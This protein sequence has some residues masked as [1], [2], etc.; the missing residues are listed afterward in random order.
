M[1]G[2]V[3]AGPRREATAPPAPGPAEPGP[4]EP[5][6]PEAGRPPDWRATRHPTAPGLFKFGG[7]GRQGP[8]AAQHIPSLTKCDVFAGVDLVASAPTPAC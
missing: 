2:P 4:A 1:L 5:V 8:E 7:H 6:L 3:P